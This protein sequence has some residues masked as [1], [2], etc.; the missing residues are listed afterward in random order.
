EMIFRPHLS[1]QL[2][3]SPASLVLF[4][5]PPGF[6]KTTL[7][8]QWRELDEPPFAW[9]TRDAADNDPVSLWTGIVEAIRRVRPDFGDAAEVALK[10]RHVDVHDALIPVVVRELDSLDGELAI[11]L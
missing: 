3:G 2:L 4:A 6:G 7:L 11:V 9:F 8:A 10:A 1:A 5:A